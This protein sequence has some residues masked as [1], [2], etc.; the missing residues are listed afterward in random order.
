[1]V[2]N[3]ATICCSCFVTDKGIQFGLFKRSLIEIIPIKK[4][5]KISLNNL[6]KKP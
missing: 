1:M 6:L 2:L 3:S 5:A 4:V